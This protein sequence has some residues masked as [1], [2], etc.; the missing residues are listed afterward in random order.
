MRTAVTLRLLLVPA[1]LLVAACDDSPLLQEPSPGEESPPLHEAQAPALTTSARWADGYLHAGSPTTPSY[2][3]VPYLSYNRSGGSMNVTK[4]A[5][6]TGRYI[7]TFSGLSAVLGTRS[8]VHVTEYG[9]NDTYCKPVNGRLVNDKLEVRCFKASTRAPANA[10]FTVVVLGINS[11]AVF[12]Y[13]HQPTSTDYLAA[14]GGTWNPRGATRVFRLGMGEYKVVFS[15]F[16]VAIP[17]GVA[18]HVQVNAVGTGKAH[19]TAADWDDEG[20][21]DLNLIV[22]CHTPAGLPVDS[23]FTALFL[24]PSEHVAYA[25]ADRPTTASYTPNPVATSNPSGGAVTITRTGVGDYIV[26]W[27]GVDPAVVDGGTVHVT[28]A[29]TDSTQCKATSLFDTGVMV[30]CFAPNGKPA[31]AY[32]SVLLGS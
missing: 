30:H 17:P 9:L 6:T 4:P 14:A 11:N 8:T 32:Y 19:C 22:Q 12:A 18:G 16:A 2:A 28:S 21:P 27:S 13:A 20:T 25:F 15:G 7:V 3:P 31:D 26:V 24:L 5:G 29:F 1:A 10:A 23:K